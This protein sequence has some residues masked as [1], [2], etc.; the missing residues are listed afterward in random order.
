MHHADLI[1]GL[2]AKL[3]GSIPVAWGIHNSSF[4]PRFTKATTIWTVST[5]AR[6]SGVLP[7]RIVCCSDASRRAHARM[8]YAS[9]KM[10]VIPNG[11]DLTV[12]LPDPE[13]RQSVRQEMGID[14]DTPL[15]GLVARFDPYKDHRNFVE[16]ATT[17]H[18]QVHDCH[19]LLCGDGMTWQNSALAGWIERAG[20]AEQC[21]LLGMREDIPRLMA[22]LDIASTASSS[23]AFPMAVGEAMACGIPCVVT[24]VGDSAIIV[25]GTGVVVA[26]RDPQALAAGWTKLLLGM[27]RDQRRQLGSAARERIRERYDIGSVVEQYERLY[28]SLAMP[29][30]RRRSPACYRGQGRG[31]TDVVL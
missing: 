20:I 10:V 4:D 9:D 3:A 29:R 22:A 12:F 31:P 7:E 2:A 8:G 17:L 21:H 24:D 30:Q 23:E 16:A 28:M 19:F 25:G 6:L 26:A 5:C 13:A 11:F 18:A 14:D 15:I 27:N 1:G